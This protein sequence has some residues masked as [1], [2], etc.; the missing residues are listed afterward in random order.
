LDYMA[1]ILFLST[2]FLCCCM[3]LLNS[4]WQEE[5]TLGDLSNRKYATSSGDSCD[6]SYS[7]RCIIN[8]VTYYGS[9]GVLL[10][11]FVNTSVCY[12]ATKQLMSRGN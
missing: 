11:Y 4:K 9:E 8:V 1:F 7:P 5:H 2:F 12:R 3:D 6:F 10:L